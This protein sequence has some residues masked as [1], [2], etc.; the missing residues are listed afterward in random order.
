MNRRYPW[1][2]F[3]RFFLTQVI[4]FN[5]FTLIIVYVLSYDDGFNRPLFTKLLIYFFGASLVISGLSSWR[6]SMP[7][8]RI[9]K[10]VLRLSSKRLA[11]LLGS[12]E[13]DIYEEGDAE[14][15][16]M[17]F[18]L[19]RLSRKLRKR[20]EQLE[21]EREETQAFMSS[22]EEGL[23][24]VSLDEKLLYF[25]SQFAATFLQ[26]S[27]LR[28]ENL[29]FTD[30]FRSPEIYEAFRKVKQ[31]GT[32]QKVFVRMNSVDGQGRHF[33]ISLNPLRKIKSH[34][35][36]GVIGIFH[37]ITDIKKAEQIRIEFVANASHELRTPLTSVKGYLET[38]KSDFKAGNMAQVPE[39]LKVISQNVDSLIELVNDLLSLSSLDHG[40]P[41][42]VETV[43]AL[44][45]S[46][47]VIKEL[48]R[49]ANEKSQVI[50]VTGEV[51]PFQAD[52]GQVEQ[53]LLNLVSN[54]IKYIPNGKNIHIRWEKGPQG[55]VVLR[56]IDN[57]PGIPEEY[58]ARL[59]ERF[60]RVDK[61]RSRDTGGTGLGLAI[62]KHIMQS[63]G[64]SVSVKS[65][66]GEGTEF[67][68]VFPQKKPF[69]VSL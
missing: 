19:E 32:S 65:Q 54:A 35:V 22:V 36:Y 13:E 2:L 29:F 7:I 60:Y 42:K 55:E 11:R 64:G 45:I 21:I 27:Q 63:H 15:S 6:F 3:F 38:L 53:V 10:K 31:S 66:F 16:E 23:V 61:G 41:L 4:L 47:H 56:V 43:N 24:S 48:A 69:H 5:F 59:F 1:R 33:S 18:A 49:M 58:H 14:Y 26:G 37:D 67:T 57:G 39:F 51:P 30:V 62:V 28:A 68:C 40:S 34:E 17:D 12:E 8:W 46:D 20:K 9:T 50:R 44:V 25:N 52:P